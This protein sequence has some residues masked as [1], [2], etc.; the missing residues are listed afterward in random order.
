MLPLKPISLKIDFTVIKIRINT[1]A[2]GV[3][4]SHGGDQPGRS[5]KTNHNLFMTLVLVFRNLCFELRYDKLEHHDNQALLQWRQL[6]PPVSLL[7]F[8]WYSCDTTTAGG[9]YYRWL[10]GWESTNLLIF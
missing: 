6:N 1:P 7:P 9:V 5:N 3:T 8:R 2:T 10:H 4:L